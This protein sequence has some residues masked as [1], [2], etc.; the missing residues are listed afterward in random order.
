MVRDLIRSCN[1]DSIFQKSFP[2]VNRF[3][4]ASCWCRFLGPPEVKSRVQWPLPDS[5]VELVWNRAQRASSSF[6][7]SGCVLRVAQS[8]VHCPSAGFPKSMCAPAFYFKCSSSFWR[9]LY[10]IG[11]ASPNT[12]PGTG[13]LSSKNI[14]LLML[15]THR[16][17]DL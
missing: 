8:S 6:C 10:L 14:T 11:A 1:T 7:R 9:R 16:T 2:W 12:P 5:V 4:V 13:S 17:R 3:S 15:D